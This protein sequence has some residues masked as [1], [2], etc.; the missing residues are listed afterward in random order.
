MNKVDGVIY[1][2]L[3]MHA[4]AEAF[5]IRHVFGFGTELPEGMASLDDVLAREPGAT[6]SVIQD[7][8]KAT[9]ISFDVTGDG[10]RAV[11]RT[12]LSVIA[13]A[14]ALS[15]ES[16][17]P[18]GATIMSAFA[19]SSFAGIVSSLAAWLL[20]GGTLSLHHPFDNEVLEEQLAEQGCDT[21]V[22]PA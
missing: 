12:H 14:L 11:P 19:P 1:S 13:G 3:A 16:D 18:Q 15:L 20:T 17:V 10:F 6:R 9:I 8:R 22:A 4:A 5:S 7:G 21:L 2:D